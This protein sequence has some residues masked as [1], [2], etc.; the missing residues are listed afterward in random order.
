MIAD[1][2]TILPSAVADTLATEPNIRKIVKII[3]RFYSLNYS[4]PIRFILI[5]DVRIYFFTFLFIAFYFNEFISF[6][7]CF[8]FNLEQNVNC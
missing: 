3:K 8:I 5:C 1:G 6:I 7:T 4:I 2:T